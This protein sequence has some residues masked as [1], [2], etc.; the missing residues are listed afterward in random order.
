M[1]TKQINKYLK[2]IFKELNFDEDL[3]IVTLSKRFDLCEYQCN[4]LFKMSSMSKKPPQEIA[5]EIIKEINSDSNNIFSEVEFCK[6]GFLNFKVKK[7]IKNKLL[8]EL[9]RT[10]QLYQPIVEEKT[11]LLDFGGPNVAKPLHV[12]HLRSAVL[13]ESLKRLYNY[14][15]YKTISDV[16]LGDYGLQI[17]QVIYGLID[18]KLDDL[19]ENIKFTIDDLERIYPLISKLSKEDETVLIEVRKITA[20][21]QEGHEEYNKLFNEIVKLSIADIKKNYDKLDVSFDLWYGESNSFPYIEQ[22]MQ[23]L[24]DANLVKDS[25][26]AKIIDLDGKYTEFLIEK[27][28]GS[29]LYST[30]DLATIY[31]RQLDFKPDEYVYV[32]DA[33]QALHFNQVFTSAKLANIVPEKTIMKHVKFGTMNGTDNKPFK[34][35][36]G[37]VLKLTTLFNMVEEKLLEKTTHDN[38]LSKDD[39]QI[40]VNSVVKFADLQN[41][42]E[43]NYIFEVDR[44]TEFHGKTGPYILYTAVRINKII[45][46]ANIKNISFNSTY[47]SEIIEELQFKILNFDLAIEACIKD[48]SMHH[49]C[50]Y[51][52]DVATSVNSLYQSVHILSMDED[53]KNYLISNL[54]LAHKTIK[55]SLDILG[56]KIPNKM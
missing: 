22:T 2:K 11:Y 10:K 42:R 47:H 35:R 43:T 9:L 31:Q 24:N 46:D 44:F 5:E 56:I 52:F 18:E 17:G 45:T 1:L 36:D 55:E 30:S 34:T 7:E 27:S 41:Y 19:T 25:Q 26:G 38:R 21:L 33:R 8:A 50:S 53:N 37:G 51:V 12:G 6:P 13:G 23:K 39:I 48:Y 32:V 20:Q 49:L 14:L 16:H 28:D 3:A 4:S 15:G 29:F 54:M 40:L